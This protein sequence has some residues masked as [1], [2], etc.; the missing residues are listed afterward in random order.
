MIESPYPGL[1]PFKRDEANLFFGREEQIEGLLEKLARN[2][3]LAVVG[4]SGCGKSSLVYAGM[5]PAL[6]MGFMPGAG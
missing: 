4:P 3:F 2:R 1:R 5:L 6:E